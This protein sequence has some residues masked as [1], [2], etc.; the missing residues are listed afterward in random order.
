MW[1]CAH[2]ARN[3]R[4]RARRGPCTSATMRACGQDLHVDG[5]LCMRSRQEGAS[6]AAATLV[7]GPTWA[8]KVTSGS[9]RRRGNSVARPLRAGSTR[10]DHEGRTRPS[11]VSGPHA[12]PTVLQVGGGGWVVGG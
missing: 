11:C 1:V 2:G 8:D 12:R 9:E 7:R 5:V 3:L 4:R 10:F 6:H